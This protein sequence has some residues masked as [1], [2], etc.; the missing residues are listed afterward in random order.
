MQIS[1]RN[2]TQG[3]TYYAVVR[4]ASN[5]MGHY[6]MT[7]LRLP[8]AQPHDV[9]PLSSGEEGT[10]SDGMVGFVSRP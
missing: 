7:M 8:G 1:L 6:A 9:G 5:S 2:L 3:G 10:P 4:G